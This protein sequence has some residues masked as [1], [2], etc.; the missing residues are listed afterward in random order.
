MDGGAAVNRDD[1]SNLEIDLR[2][3]ITSAVAAAVTSNETEFQ[4][5]LEARDCIMRDLARRAAI[6]EK[7]RLFLEGD[8]GC[9]LDPTG[10]LND[11]LRE[12]RCQ[13]A[14][15]LPNKH[16]NASSLDASHSHWQT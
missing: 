14:L 6:S 15:K 3:E 9:A 11:V 10:C 1:L 7:Q 5:E 8:A 4:Q 12:D 13:P 2:G 16:A